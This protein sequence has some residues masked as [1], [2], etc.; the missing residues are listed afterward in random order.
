M[1]AAAARPSRP[2][3]PPAHRAQALSAC[4]FSEVK[5][6]VLQAALTATKGRSGGGLG[7]IRLS[8]FKA[9]ESDAKGERSP[10]RSQCIFVQG[11]LQLRATPT[12]ALRVFRDEGQEKVFEVNF[13]GESGIDAGGVY[14]EGLQRIIDDLFS[15][16][17][18]LLVKCAWAVGPAAVLLH[19]RPGTS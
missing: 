11:Y 7:T 14:R 12:A 6:S 2:L 16:R 1:P 17:F 3:H 8:N 4:V 18:E 9:I 19:A 13:E 15:D 5:S 10:E